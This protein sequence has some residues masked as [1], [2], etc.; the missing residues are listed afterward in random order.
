MWH[1]DIIDD[2]TSLPYAAPSHVT[3]SSDA[4]RVIDEDPVSS[5]NLILIYSRRS[6]SKSNFATGPGWNREHLW[7]NS[8]GIDKVHPSYSDLHALRPADENV[9]SARSN[10]W[11]DDASA[12]DGSFRSPGHAEAPL[13]K[14]D[15]NSWEP[16]TAYQGDIARAMFYMDVRYSGDQANEPDLVLTDQLHLINGD[17]AYMG[18][19]STLLRWHFAD[20]VSDEERLRNDRV[21][22]YQNNRNPFIDHPEFVNGVFLDILRI[23][24]VGDTIRLS[25][26][27][28]Y[29]FGLLAAG[30]RVTNIAPVV[31]GS[32]VV[33][34]EQYVLQIGTGDEVMNFFQIGLR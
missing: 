12:A 30:D 23:S 25:W 33:E 28:R 24:K 7:P 13:T 32:P 34:G 21:H 5:D 27:L 11:F 26:P 8:L 20:P 16:P 1:V 18:R 31:I 2:H 29:D 10:K 3:D 9:N 4:L 14:A 22:Q 15:V 17:N 6:E 19:L